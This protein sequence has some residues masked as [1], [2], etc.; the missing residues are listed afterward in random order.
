MSLF[1]SVRRLG[2]GLFALGLMAQGAFA[3]SVATPPT[4]SQMQVARQLVEANGEAR[5]FDGVIPNLLDGAALG[6]LQTNPDL[7]KQ[8]RDTALALRP[9]FEKRKGEIIDILA[10]AY[11]QRFTEQELKDALAFFSTPVGKKLVTDRTQIVQQ[12]VT[13]IQAW[14]GKVNADAMNRIREEMKKQGYDL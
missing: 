13:S 8:L 7:A 4:A 11:A 9:E 1:P 10:T 5:A 6:F 3:Q 2:L 12:A 14:G